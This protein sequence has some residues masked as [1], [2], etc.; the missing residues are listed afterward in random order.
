MSCPARREVSPCLKLLP[1]IG[2]KETPINLSQG[3]YL[4]CAIYPVTWDQGTG[5]YRRK[6]SMLYTQQ[7]YHS[8]NDNKLTAS[9][10]PQT[11]TEKINKGH[12]LT[13]RKIKQ[14]GKMRSNQEQ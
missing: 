2:L 3:C 4:Q 14:K 11:L 10:Y 5:N 9:Y 6:K 7:E 8:R 12:A 13:R 1:L